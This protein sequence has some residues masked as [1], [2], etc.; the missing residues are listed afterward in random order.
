MVGELAVVALEEAVVA[1]EEAV[2]AV[3]EAVVAVVGV[4]EVLEEGVGALVKGE[5]EG[6]EHFSSTSH[7]PYSEGFAVAL[8]H[9]LLLLPSHLIHWQPSGFILLSIQ[10]LQS[11]KFPQLSGAASLPLGAA[12]TASPQR[13]HARQTTARGNVSIVSV[14]AMVAMR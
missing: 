8:T 6:G 2:V 7:I 14:R 1:L 5:T 9:R 3:E 12:I 13:Q 10:E 4:A 11:E